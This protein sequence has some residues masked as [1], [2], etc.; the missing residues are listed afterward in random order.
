MKINNTRQLLRVQTLLVLGLILF[1]LLSGSAISALEDT[2]PD[3]RDSYQ[4]QPLMPPPGIF[5]LS[6]PNEWH[7][8]AEVHNSEQIPPRNYLT[9]PPD[10]PAFA[11][12]RWPGVLG[13]GYLFVS[14]FSASNPGQMTS[15]NLILDNNGEPVYFGPL[16]AVP[17][18]VDFKKQPNGLL[19]YFTH[20]KSGWGFEALNSNYMPVKDYIAA[21]DPKTGKEYLADH[22]DLQ[23]L[24]SDNVLFLISDARTV[25]MSEIVPGGSKEATVIGCL[26]QE[27]DENQ[28]VVFQWSSWDEIPIT[29][30]YA[31]LDRNPLR[32]IHCNSV[33]ED[34]DGNL[35]LS[36]R[37]LEEI[38]KINRQTGK[39]IWRMGGRQNEFVFLN[40]DG[41][42]VQHDARRLANGHITLYDNAELGEVKPSRGV[43]YRVDEVNKTVE[44]VA[45]FYNTPETYGRFMGNMQ[46]LMN[47]NTLIGWGTS[48]MPLLTEFDVVGQKILEIN[49]AADLGT[50]RAF[51]FQWQ[52]YPTWP[53]AL[54]ARLDGNTVHLHFSWNG[55]TE[56]TGFKILSGQD[57]THLSELA[58]VSRNG[59]ETVYSFELPQEES[60]REG[61]WFFRV[62][63][64]D[65]QGNEGLISN[66]AYVVPGGKHAFI[67]MAAA[68][69]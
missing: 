49:T 13:D 63:P 54:V 7:H 23:I 57:R 59:F 25:D 20:T 28:N 16:T 69:Y 61:F 50:Y 48:G 65:S 21:D 33:E 35:L 19:T 41:F 64:L 36:S 12:D 6:A 18:S 37:N 15:Y 42:S 66:G 58:T 10:L 30:T 43:E 24:S 47:G 39:I 3:G 27:V 38:T 44:K 40:D 46:R 62:M 22:H 68:D 17:N 2:L 67:S 5:Q 14:P 56:T 32:Y 9:A 4:S 51:R 11:V 34:N 31:P 29:D 53:S 52:G 45:E 55:S 26:I 60:A 8:E 1:I